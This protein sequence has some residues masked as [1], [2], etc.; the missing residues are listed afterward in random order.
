M[1]SGYLAVSGRGYKDGLACA[2]TGY[3][4]SNVNTHYWQIWS[5]LCANPSGNQAFRTLA[6]ML[7]YDGNPN[8]NYTFSTSLWSPN[9]TY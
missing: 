7:G 1:P 8:G 5:N 6:W 4:Y 9:Q 3:I 2:T